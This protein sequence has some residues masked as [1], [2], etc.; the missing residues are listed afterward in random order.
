MGLAILRLKDSELFEEKM[1]RLT[2]ELAMQM[3][4][5]KNL[6]E[7]IKKILKGIGYGF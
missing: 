3:E 2:S 6:D 5:V 7:E 4:E 1:K